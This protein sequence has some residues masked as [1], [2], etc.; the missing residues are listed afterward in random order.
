VKVVDVTE[1]QF[2]GYCKI[3]ANCIKFSSPN[4]SFIR[5]DKL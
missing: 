4:Y 5:D 2:H 3:C 1:N